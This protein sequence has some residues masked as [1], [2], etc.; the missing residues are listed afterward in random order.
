MQKHEPPDKKNGTEIEIEKRKKML[1]H[2]QLQA[3]LA[4]SPLWV[5][6]MSPRV[7]VSEP[8]ISSV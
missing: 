7:E 6:K 2:S 1:K 4:G 8:Q 5:A 3:R